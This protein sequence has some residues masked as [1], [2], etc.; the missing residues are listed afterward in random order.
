MLDHAT[1]AEEDD[2][3]TP[4]RYVA[5][6][7]TTADGI[8][9]L[10]ELANTWVWYLFWPFKANESDIRG[11]H[12]ASEIA[13]SSRPRKGTFEDMVKERDGS[14]CIIS[15]VIDRKSATRALKEVVADVET[16]HIFKGA[17]AAGKRS[18][19]SLA[20]YATWNILR[21]FIALSK[22]QVAELDDN[23]DYIYNGITLEHTLHSIFDEFGW[24]LCPDPDHHDRYHFEYFIGN[25]PLTV[26]GRDIGV[27]S[28]EGCSAELRPRRQL[29]QFHYSLAKVLRASS[30]GKV[31]ESIMKRFLRGGSKSFTMNANDLDIY[32]SS[33]RMSL[34]TV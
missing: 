8:D 2:G 5:C 26:N 4:R 25:P 16:A 10:I 17:V 22:E 24:S 21:Q 13:T 6:A 12:S 28:F 32:L 29:I 7:I 19:N 23:I 1:G 9:Q 11:H 18:K 33:E 31:I 15:K 3:K 27:I 20:E 30:A 34:M 14:R